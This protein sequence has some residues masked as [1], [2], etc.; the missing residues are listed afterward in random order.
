MLSLLLRLRYSFL[1]TV[2]T[3]VYVGVFKSTRHFVNIFQSKAVRKKTKF[4]DL[5][6]KL[7]L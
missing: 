3:S 5:G 6:Q 2:D 7:I 4:Q 1:A